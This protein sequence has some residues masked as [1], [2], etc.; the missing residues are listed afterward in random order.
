[1]SVTPGLSVQAR[2]Q[3]HQPSDRTTEL[4]CGCGFIF[5]ILGFRH[6]SVSAIDDIDRK[7][8]PDATGD[9]FGAGSGFSRN[10]G[11]KSIGIPNPGSFQ[12]A[13]TSPSPPPPPPVVIHDPKTER[14]LH[15]SIVATRPYRAGRVIASTKQVWLC[16]TSAHS[17]L[18]KLDRTHS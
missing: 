2:S 5:A 17:S 4:D 8:E 6:L 9:R 10:G 3:S 16:P 12:A 14:T 18:S 13:P 11:L 1:M 15:C 7:R